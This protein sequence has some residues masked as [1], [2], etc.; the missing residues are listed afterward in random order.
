MMSIE[1]IAVIGALVVSGID[2]MVNV[3]GFCCAGRSSCVVWG[4]DSVLDVQHNSKR[5]DTPREEEATP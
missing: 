5:E 3:F 4:K 1:L 2:L